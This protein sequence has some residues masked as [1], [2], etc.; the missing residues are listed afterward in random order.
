[1]SDT[2]EVLSTELGRALRPLADGVSSPAQAAGLLARLGWALPPGVADLGLTG[3][4]VSDVID[5]LLVLLRSTDAEREDAILMA[6]RAADLLRAIAELLANVKTIVDALPTLPA[7][8]A[9]YL[10]RTRIDQELPRRLLDYLL[11]DYLRTVAN[12]TYRVLKLAGIVDARDMPADTANYQTAHERLSFH[13][14]RIG[15]LLSPSR[16]WAGETYGWGTNAPDL[17]HLLGN[18]GDV[19]L[20]LGGTAFLQDMPPELE[21]ALNGS[22]PPAGTPPFKSLSVHLLRGI[23]TDTYVIGVALNELR[24]TVVGGTDSGLALTPFALGS[25]T[26]DFPLLPI[27]GGELSFVIE[28]STTL[29][30][31]VALNL[32]PRVSPTL[33]AL[34]GGA[35]SFTGQVRGGLRFHSRAEP[36]VL[37]AGAGIELSLLEAQALVGAGVTASGFDASFDISMRELRLEVTLG[38]ADSFVT[39]ITKSA[40]L[41]CAIDFGMR[42]STREGLRFTG[43]GALEVSIPLHLE[44]GPFCIDVIWLTLGVAAEGLILES[45]VTGSG[46]LGPLSVSV[47]RIGGR[48]NL[49]FSEGNLGPVDLSFAFKPPTGLG[50]ALDAGPVSGGGFISFDEPRGRYAGILQLQVLS[51]SVTAIGLLDTKLPDGR[52]GYSFLLIITTE[53]SPIQLGY[54]F[55]LNGVGGLAGINRTINAEALRLGVYSGSLDHILFPRDPIQNAPQLISDLSLIFPPAEGQYTFGPMAKLGWGSP[56]LIEITLGII[57]ELPSPVRIALLGQIGMYLPKREAPVVEIHLDFVAMI[58]FGAKLLSLD[59]T[60]RDSRIVVFTLSG[61]MALRLTWGDQPNFAVALGGFHPH[62]PTPPGFPALRRLTLALGEGDRIRLTCQ[63]YQALTTNSLQFGAHVELFVDVGVSV[64]GWIGFDA[65]FIFSPFSFEV[66]FTA[67][68]EVAAGGIKLAGV[69]F[70]GTLSGPTPW[71]IRG[72]A[73]LSVLFVEITAKV[74]EKFGEEHNEELLPVDPWEKLLE[75]LIDVRN[76]SATQLPGTAPVVSIAAPSGST[77]VM[78]DPGGRATWRQKVIPLDRSVMR[79]GN[80]PTPSAVKYTVDRV[81]DEF[82]KGEFGFS[83]VT[84]FFPPGQFNDL[85]DSEKLSRP[86]FESMNA[87]IEL[88]SGAAYFGPSIPAAIYY[89]TKLIDSELES[90]KGSRFG[91]GMTAHLALAEGGAIAR[92]G[93]VRSG[94]KAFVGASK[95]KQE[96]DKFVVVSTTDLSQHGTIAAGATKGAATEALDAYLSEQPAE[97]GKWQIIPEHELEAA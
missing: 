76:W 44:L 2:L 18:I 94:M 26:R 66:D 7:L 54:G 45:S 23:G 91:F 56:T 28:A 84:D 77:T 61:D 71:R 36:A 21:T 10:A 27:G 13:P 19:L 93:A 58:D 3:L 30:G 46:Q 14:E 25:I 31:G 1:M 88:G 12:G 69:S 43:S 73:T 81:S 16:D 40:S 47:E 41:S 97:R 5:K 53:F 50:I 52:P 85:T 96:G 64:H 62:F 37:L 59:A 20:G 39:S 78:L 48:A 42:Y 55:T 8:T 29:D 90:R 79:F 74:D 17:D 15:S 33:Q 86:S 32:R 9:D 89:E 70:E 87:G 65:L 72:Q 35:P 83:S 4:T 51:I 67:G 49:A 38:E 57:I 80:A 75:S 6:T 92:A 22:S 34:A 82:T 11:V 68:L 63:A 60:L 95:L 24:S